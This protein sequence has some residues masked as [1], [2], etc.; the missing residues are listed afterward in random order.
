PDRE[1][2]RALGARRGALAPVLAPADGPRLRAED[3]TG[4]AGALLHPRW[5]R[6]RGPGRRARTAPAR[7]AGSA[8]PGE[9]RPRGGEGPASGAVPGR[10]GQGA[11]REGGSGEGGL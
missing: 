1:E 4:G 10:G 3:G 7:P 11:S 9:G 2:E 8:G 5:L 6:L